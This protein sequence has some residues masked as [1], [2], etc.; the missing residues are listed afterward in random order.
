MPS[1][2]S[3]NPAGS[4]PSSETAG[5]SATSRSDTDGGSNRGTGVSTNSGGRGVVNDGGA[6]TG[7]TGVGTSIDGGA[8][9]RPITTT[10]VMLLVYVLV[11]AAASAYLLK[12]RDNP[13]LDMEVYWRAAQVLHGLNPNTQD[14][15]APTLVTAGELELPFTY[16]PLSALIFYPLGAMTLQ[17]AWTVT[18]ITGVALLGIYVWVTLRLAPFSRAWF[19][20]RIVPSVLAYLVLFGV[21]WNLYPVYFT[22]VFGQVNLIL[23]ILILWDLGRRSPHRWGNGILT[24]FAAGFKVTPAAMGLVPLAQGR[25]KTIIGMAIGL[26][27]TIIVSAIFLPHEVWDYF[28]HQLW[29]TSR[30]GED[31]RI[32]NMSFNG[33]LQM[34][35]LPDGVTGPVWIVLVL[36]A[37]VGGGLAI[38]R[39]SRSGD[40]FSATVLGALVMLLISP[41]SWEHHWVWMLPL[42]VAL[43]PRNPRAASALE[44]AVAALVAGLLLW[45]FTS[46]PSVFAAEILGP[47]YPQEVVLNGP[48]WLERISTAPVWSAVVAGLWIALR[49]QQQTRRDPRSAAPPRS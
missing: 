26:A 47:D 20:V 37:V 2:P 36:V 8:S 18:A 28:T 12:V 4:P 33:A 30:V 39:V 42:L 3:P 7:G 43:I 21:A 31:A 11:T 17:Q 25:W 41:I 22:L 23:A 5:S 48:P 13:G 34:L 19:G 45:T 9:R 44:W 29:Q 27:T 46:A 15:Y 16:P 32:S 1:S 14:L 24:G 49:P 40:M 35:N 6:G 38:R 10:L